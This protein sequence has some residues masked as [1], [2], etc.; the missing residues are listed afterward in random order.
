M[1]PQMIRKIEVLAE[2]P[3][4]SQ[5][6]LLVCTSLDGTL[7]GIKYHILK[8]GKNNIYF[9]IEQAYKLYDFLTDFAN[10]YVAESI[11]Q[12]D[13]NII[14]LNSYSGDCPF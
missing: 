1:K 13:D 10:Y 7:K 4:D 9:S 8:E 3:N 6:G 11:E 12:E 5:E 14:Y 2:I